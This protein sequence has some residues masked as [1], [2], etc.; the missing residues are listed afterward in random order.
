MKD[1]LHLTISGQKFTLSPSETKF[2]AEHLHT[3]I[4][5]PN[6]ALNFAH[7]RTERGGRISLLRGATVETS[8]LT[9]C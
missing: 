7:S 5:Q 1:N 4:A 9:D 6:V 2:L 8:A 3:A